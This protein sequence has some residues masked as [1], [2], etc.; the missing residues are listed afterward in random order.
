MQLKPWWPSGP[1]SVDV[2]GE[3]TFYNG[4]VQLTDVFWTVKIPLS[5]KEVSC[6]QLHNP[7][8]LSY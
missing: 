3:A 5:A 7:G 2:L 1:F 8:Q 6:F 4:S